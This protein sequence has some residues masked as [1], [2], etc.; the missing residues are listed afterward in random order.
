MKIGLDFHGVIDTEPELFSKLSR[1]CINKGWEVHIL[2]GQEDT[3]E[4]RKIIENYGIHFTHFFSITT[5]HKNIGTPITYDEKDN[6]WMD[7][8]IWDKTKSDYCKGNNINFHIDDSDTYGKYF[9]TTYLK[10][11]KIDGTIYFSPV[12]LKIFDE[13]LLLWPEKLQKVNT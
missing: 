13:V 3:P 10:F 11:Q 8:F 6:P 2:T 1:A 9:E 5:F 4:L 12:V 7:D